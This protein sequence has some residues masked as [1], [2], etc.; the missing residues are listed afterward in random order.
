MA[1]KFNLE[2]YIKNPSRKVVTRD[3][4]N[5][6]IICTD[7]IDFDKPVLALVME[8]SGIENLYSY[9]TNGQLFRTDFSDQDLFFA[10]EKREGWINLYKWDNS[11][12]CYV[13]NPFSSE[14]KAIEGGKTSSNYLKTIKIEWEV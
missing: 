5:V 13:S 11:I 2:E 4:R 9:R 6:R 1:M 12:G 3:G 14:E 7:R 8:R 10:S